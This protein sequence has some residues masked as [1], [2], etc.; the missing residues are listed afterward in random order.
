MISVVIPCFGETYAKFLPEA[1]ASVQAQTY[2]DWEVVIAA[3]MGA[4]GDDSAYQAAHALR[5]EEAC[6]SG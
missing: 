4:D 6:L 5:K 2:T 3:G 1:V